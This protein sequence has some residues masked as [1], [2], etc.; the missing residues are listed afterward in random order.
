[1]CPGNKIMFHRIQIKGLQTISYGIDL[2]ANPLETDFYILFDTTAGMRAVIEKTK[3][4][5]DKLL[6]ILARR[7]DATVGIG[8]YRNANDEGLSIGFQN[9]REMTSI[10]NNQGNRIEAGEEYVK[11]AI[12]GLE[13]RGGLDV[14]NANLIALYKVATDPTIG[15]RE[16]SRKIIIMVGNRPGNEP[17]CVIP[18]LTITRESVVAVMKT[19]R[20]SVIVANFG[21]MN[22]VPQSF[23]CAVGSAEANQAR[24]IAVRT[25]GVEVMVRE[26]SMLCKAIQE[27]LDN[28]P[29][30]FAVEGSTCDPYIDSVHIPPLPLSLLPGG[31]QSV[32]N[33]VSIRPG[34]WTSGNSFSCRYMYTESGA[35]LP[36]AIVRIKGILPF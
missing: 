34:I 29:K 1:M 25:M 26:A 21:Q 17:S 35:A 6:S 28:L 16:R 3:A 20:M 7:P 24:D 13:A 4:K 11:R 30:V 18:R 32:E 22:N 10:T 33:I 19:K 31:N 8:Y 5:V 36:T 14:D 2:S 23:G 15:W 9:V 27:G 12:Y